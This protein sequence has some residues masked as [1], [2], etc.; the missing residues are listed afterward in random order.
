MR[1]C[2]GLPAGAKGARCS[3]FTDNLFVPV[4]RFESKTKSII[5]VPKLSCFSMDT[6]TDKSYSFPFDLR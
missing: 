2:V 1:L 5:A 3:H 4:S 6:D